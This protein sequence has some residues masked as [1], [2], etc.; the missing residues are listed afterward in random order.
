MRWLKFNAVGAM[1]MVVQLG[2]LGFFVHAL[3]MHYMLATALAV[4]IAVLHNFIWHRRWTWA[5]RVVSPHARTCSTLLRFHL[6][7]GLVS[8]LGNIVCMR[9]LVGTLRLEPVVANL[10]AVT[11]CSLINFLLADRFVFPYPTSGL[12]Q[13]R[14][15]PLK[16]IAGG[17]I[18]RRLS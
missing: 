2:S 6:G 12:R 11:L 16:A 1:G 14:K 15:R 5:D 8:I 13:H 4:E 7:N 18:L 3:G 17:H 10:L 9:I